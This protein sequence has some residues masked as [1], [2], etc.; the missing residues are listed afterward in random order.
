MVPKSLQTAES[1]NVILVTLVGDVTANA[2][3]MEGALVLDAS[4]TRAGEERNA[5]SED[6]LGNSM[7]AV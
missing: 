5:K 3:D 6:V 7:I 4:V 1:A 2:V